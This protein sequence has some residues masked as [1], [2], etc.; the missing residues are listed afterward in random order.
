[1]LATAWAMEDA[2]V[3]CGVVL[4]GREQQAHGG[5]V[6]RS[7]CK[8]SEGTRLESFGPSPR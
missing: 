5:T 4:L 6:R 2:E 8:E 7:E 3:R 1:M